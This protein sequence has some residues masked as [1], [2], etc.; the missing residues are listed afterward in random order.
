MKQIEKYGN[1]SADTQARM[2]EIE[3]SIIERYGNVPPK[4]NAALF[5][6]ADNLDLLAECRK[7]LAED[8]LFVEGHRNPLVVSVGNLTASIQAS[9]KS[10]GCTPYAEGLLKTD[11]GDDANDF[12]DNL[13]K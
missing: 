6:L 9:L 3:A 5:L 12:V 2:A 10:L 8:G 11:E 4:F 1:Y 7:S 13:T